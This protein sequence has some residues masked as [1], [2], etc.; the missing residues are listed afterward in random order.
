MKITPL[1]F[2]QFAWVSEVALIILYT[3]LIV[4]F[5]SS[6]H[7]ELWHSILPTLERLIAAQG[8]AAGAGPLLSDQI[9]KT[10]EK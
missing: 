9:H 7:V 3:M 2:I 8:L 6:D 4:P 5:L 1:K 10:K